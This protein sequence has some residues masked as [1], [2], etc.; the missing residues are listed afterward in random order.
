MPSLDKDGAALFT[1]RLMQ[2]HVRTSDPRSSWIAP[3]FILKHT[4]HNKDFF[5][6]IV[7]VGIEI[8]LWRPF[9]KSLIVTN[10]SLNVGIA[11]ARPEKNPRNRNGR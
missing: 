10:L 9:N 5:T 6:T 4:I 7:P 1:K 2:A 11:S 3:V 8:G